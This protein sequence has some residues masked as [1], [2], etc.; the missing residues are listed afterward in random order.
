MRGTG[1]SK[2]PTLFCI[3]RHRFLVNIHLGVLE[4][5]VISKMTEDRDLFFV[6]R[7]VY[8]STDC[9]TKWLPIV[10]VIVGIVL[11]YVLKVPESEE[12]VILTTLFEVISGILGFLVAASAIIFA[13]PDKV[14]RS[15]NDIARDRK[16]PYD[17]IIGTMVFTS[18]LAVILVIFTLIAMLIP[19]GSDL[20]KLLFCEILSFSFCVL[21]LCGHV[22]LHLFAARTFIKNN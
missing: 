22:L 16:N 13:L 14:V 21:I 6:C 9:T 10:F 17:V 4:T 5:K 11:F 15:M 2:T 18:L 1:N 8:N 20:F 12:R 7:D 3:Y 19:L